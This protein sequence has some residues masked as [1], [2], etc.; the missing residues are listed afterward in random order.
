MRFVFAA[1]PVAAAVVS[2][3]SLAFANAAQAATLQVPSTRFAT[4]QSALNAAKP[5]DVVLVSPKKSADGLWRENLHINTTGIT[6]EG[7]NGATLDGTGLS[8]TGPPYSWWPEY[9]V[10]T[11]V[12]GV[13]VTAPN[14]TIKT[15]TVQNFIGLTDDGYGEVGGVSLRNP[16]RAVV[17]GCVLRKNSAG[18]IILGG[19][20]TGQVSL[21]ANTF[22]DNYGSGVH[23]S[24]TTGSTLI[25]S[26]RFTNNGFDPNGYVYGLRSPGLEISG[27]G[28]TVRG[29]TLL[30]S[31]GDGINAYDL[32][33]ST[34]PV[35]IENNVV[36]NSGGS[37]IWADHLFNGRI[38][39][40]SVSRSADSGIN[41]YICTDTLVSG[42]SLTQNAVRGLFLNYDNEGCIISQNL[43]TG[44]NPSATND[45]S[46]G[47]IV[48]EYMYTDPIDPLVPNRITQ[49]VV[50]NNGAFDLL[51]RN[52]YYGEPLINLWTGNLFNSANSSDIH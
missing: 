35:V 41:V 16:A 45:G 14:V 26:N 10:T 17:T 47:G 44:N 32:W 2:L 30:G 27:T 43:V 46:S 31:A 15:L 6:L 13:S 5:G 8:V 38:R 49:N 52:A 51:D 7:R 4:I 9:I 42:N 23:G 29:N 33:S 40:N 11:G 20:N 12:S 39:S 22:A 28:I 50:Q 19:D 34:V 48:S 18:V 25:E 37:G 1:R 36:D 3:A 24:L 21:V